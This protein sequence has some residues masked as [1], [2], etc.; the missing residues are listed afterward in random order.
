MPLDS[1]GAPTAPVVVHWFAPFA[2]HVFVSQL[3]VAHVTS[4]A[5]EPAQLMSLHASSALQVTVQ[6]PT[7]QLMLW[8]ASLAVHITVH[9]PVVHMMS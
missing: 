4:H 2:G 8:Q 9:E 5:H 3:P 6:R 7:P 1:H